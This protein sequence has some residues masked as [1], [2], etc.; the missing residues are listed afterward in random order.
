MLLVKVLNKFLS[1]SAGNSNDI[2]ENEEQTKKVFYVI[3]VTTT[4]KKNV[5]ITSE[6]QRLPVIDTIYH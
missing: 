3:L 2:A 6:I 5:K 1:F 4:I